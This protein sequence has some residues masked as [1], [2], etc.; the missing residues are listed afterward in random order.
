MKEVELFGSC[1]TQGEIRNSY[2]ILVI[3]PEGK[4]ESIWETRA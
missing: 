2:K 3:M 4:K 1:S